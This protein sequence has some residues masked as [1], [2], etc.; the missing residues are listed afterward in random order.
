MTTEA[1]AYVKKTYTQP[2]PKKEFPG[3]DNYY[4]RNS[5]QHRQESKTSPDVKF[6]SRNKLDVRCSEL[7]KTDF[8]FS[9]R[10]IPDE[11]SE[12]DS[13]RETTLSD[14]FR[15]PDIGTDLK[16]FSS[17]LSKSTTQTFVECLNTYIRNKHLFDSQVYK[18]AGIDRRLFSKMMSD[19]AYKPSKDTAIAICFALKLSLPEAND[20]LKR[21]GYS[22]SH[23]IKRDIVFEYF[24][25]N[26]FHKV[27]DI[28][29]ILSELGEKPLGR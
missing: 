2:S 17:A 9:E 4:S 3:T 18:A 5:Y 21:A 6:S 8:K 22:L 10:G 29:T 16:S 25:R 15:R 28:N 11:I 20:L 7:N 14:V 26:A 1:R 19:S 24:L 27:T 23:S 12:I 13:I